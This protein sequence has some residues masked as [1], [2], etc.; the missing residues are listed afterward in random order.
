MQHADRDIAFQ[1]RCLQLMKDASP[2]EVD[3]TDILY[4]E[5]RVRINQGRGQLYGTQFTQQNGTHVPKLI[6]DEKNVDARR[7]SI[8]MGPLSEQIAMMYE[9]C[10]FT[11][12]KV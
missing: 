9:Q 5:D 3:I 2:S 10:P 12:N 4:L 8:G 11:E 1:A 7:F 6:E